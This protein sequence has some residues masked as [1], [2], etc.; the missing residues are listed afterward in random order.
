MKV[1][2]YFGGCPKCGGTDGYVNVGRNHWFICVEHKTKWCVGS[3]LFS[4]WRFETEEE[5][6]HLWDSLGLDDFTEVEPLL[7]NDPDILGGEHLV[8]VGAS[9]GEVR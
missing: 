3:N 2:S 9:K 8:I 5:Q 4:A 7:C 1:D 6:R